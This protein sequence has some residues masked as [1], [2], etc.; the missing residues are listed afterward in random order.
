VKAFAGALAWLLCL[1][2]T[3][4]T[5]Q[6]ANTITEAQAYEIEVEAYTYFYPL[7]LMDATRRQAVNVEAGKFVGRGPMNAFTHVPTFPLADFRDVGDD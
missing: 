4:A 1:Q 6:S 7:V 3:V 2:F 5:A